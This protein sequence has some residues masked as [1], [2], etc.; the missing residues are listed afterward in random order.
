[1]VRTRA[2]RKMKQQ[3]PPQR[4]GKNDEGHDDGHHHDDCPKDDHDDHGGDPDGDPDGDNHGDDNDPG[5]TRSSSPKRSRRQD[6]TPH[7]STRTHLVEAWKSHRQMHHRFMEYYTG[8]GE[9]NCRTADPVK[10]M[11]DNMQRL[12]SAVNAW[13]LEFALRPEECADLTSDQKRAIVA[14]LE[15]QCLQEEWDTLHKLCP[16]QMC[17]SFHVFFIEALVIRDIFSVIVENPFWYFDGKLNP[18][19]EGLGD[20]G[21]R[22]QYLFERFAQ[23]HEIRASAW[24]TETMR[25]ANA[26]RPLQVHNPE[27]GQHHEACRNDTASGFAKSMLESEPLKFLLKK[28]KSPEQEEGRLI[29]LVTAYREAA[30]CTTE[31]LQ[32]CQG[33]P[34]IRRS[35]AQ[36]GE[37]YSETSP[38]AD[39]HPLNCRPENDYETTL[40]N[41]RRILLVMHP[42]VDIR[43]PKKSYPGC[44]TV[45]KAQVVVEDP[46]AESENNP[47]RSYT[48]E[49]LFF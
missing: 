8:C 29:G 46:D 3:D 24:L 10:D 32:L 37:T 14:S 15:G 2:K 38:F 25:L 41:G 35:L 4:V 39:A 36:I 16:T 47:Q 27:L 9:D 19:D 17:H 13:A 6:D 21:A 12:Y 40:L 43:M 22:L 33:I 20:F 45:E 31:N 26:V 28:L 23:T 1:M 34:R 42:S 11:Q 18:Q 5:R 7:D 49:A 30:R 48:E 44:T